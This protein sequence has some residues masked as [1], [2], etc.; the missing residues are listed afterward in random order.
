M[1][2]CEWCGKECGYTCENGM[3][4]MG[5]LQDD[6]YCQC[7]ELHTKLKALEEQLAR[8]EEVL[9]LYYDIRNWSV[10]R[11]TKNKVQ[12]ARWCA[13]FGPIPAQAYFKDK[14]E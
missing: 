1:D 4:H 10:Y 8:A 9:K 13:D 14:G 3:I 11:Y 12:Y 2:K 6:P 5:E 7:T